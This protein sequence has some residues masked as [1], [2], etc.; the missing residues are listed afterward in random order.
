MTRLKIL[1][2]GI[3]I[4]CDSIALGVGW[5]AGR[6]ARPACEAMPRERQP[7]DGGQ[8]DVKDCLATHLLNGGA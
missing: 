7:G 2:F 5:H 6:Q 3:I 4:L 1:V 8:Y